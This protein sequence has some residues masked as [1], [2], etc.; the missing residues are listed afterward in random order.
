MTAWL[1]RLRMLEVVNQ[2]TMTSMVYFFVRFSDSLPN[3]VPSSILMVIFYSN[4]HGTVLGRGTLA[5][6]LLQDADDHG[7]PAKLELAAP[8]AA[9]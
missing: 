6:I 3:V 2:P 9:G 5:S 1:R 8:A 7:V 4:S